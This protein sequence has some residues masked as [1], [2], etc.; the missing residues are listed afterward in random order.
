MKQF[1]RAYFIF[2]GTYNRK[3]S[4]T[5]VAYFLYVENHLK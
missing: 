3:N 1:I 5:P 2:Y 4:I